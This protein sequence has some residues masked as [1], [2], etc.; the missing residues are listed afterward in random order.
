MSG[1]RVVS[2]NSTTH[3][4]CHDITCELS[5]QQASQPFGDETLSVPNDEDRRSGI[6]P[7]FF[8]HYSWW[9]GKGCLVYCR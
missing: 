3:P 2:K 8:G 5:S 1:G 6:L 4:C 7:R 9:A